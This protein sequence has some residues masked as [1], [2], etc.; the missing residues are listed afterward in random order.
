MKKPKKFGTEKLFY[1]IIF[2]TIAFG[3]EFWNR[4]S[5]GDSVLLVV[6][7]YTIT[8]ITYLIFFYNRLILTSNSIVLK[9]FNPIKRNI[10][11]PFDRVTC[12]DLSLDGGNLTFGKVVIHTKENEFFKISFMSELYSMEEL[13]RLLVENDIEVRKIGM[14]W[15]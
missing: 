6:V 7:W 9:Y 13:A 3:I 1:A 10:E 11:L 8:V 12:V 15:S 2:C 5:Y 4:I 14:F